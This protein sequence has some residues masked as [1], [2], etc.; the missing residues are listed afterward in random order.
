M[1]HAYQLKDLHLDIHK[2]GLMTL[3]K[4]DRDQE[5]KNRKEESKKRQERINRKLERTRKIRKSQIEK[6]RTI[7]R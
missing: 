7:K 2:D 5:N 6:S 1:I 3:H 4:I